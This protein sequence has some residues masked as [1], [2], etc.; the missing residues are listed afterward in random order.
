MFTTHLT[1]EQWDLNLCWLMIVG[2]Y[3]TQYVGDCNSNHPIGNPDLNQPGF[4]GMIEGFWALLNC[5]KEWYTKQLAHHKSGIRYRS[6]L[7]LNAQFWCL[8][9]P[10]CVNGSG[11]EWLKLHQNWPEL[12]FNISCTSQNQVTL[13]LPK[14]LSTGTWPKL[15]WVPPFLVTS[16]NWPSAL[17]LPPPWRLWG[18]TCWHRPP[19]GGAPVCAGRRPWA[20][21]RWQ[22]RR[23]RDET[24]KLRLN[25]GFLKCGYPWFS[26][27]SRWDLP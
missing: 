25:G 14:N 11:I 20:L 17:R 15:L 7:Q 3:T 1:M 22:Q 2:D 8:S 21:N 5:C 12:S 27:I 26:S 13:R 16:C 19:S 9:R 18:S 6:W 4:N 24:W 10:N 23:R